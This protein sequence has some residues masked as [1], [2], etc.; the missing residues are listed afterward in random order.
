MY[1]WVLIDIYNCTA[2]DELIFS[3]D[4][5]CLQYGI[6]RRMVMWWWVDVG[7]NSGGGGCD[8]G[9][10]SPGLGGGGVRDNHDN[11]EDDDHKKCKGDAYIF[12]KK[13]TRF[14]W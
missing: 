2:G 10:D 13:L 11:V 9:D 3:I 5:F 14:L 1:E 8:D 6:F 7:S 12:N 4:Y